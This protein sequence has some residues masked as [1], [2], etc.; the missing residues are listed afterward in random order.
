MDDED[1]DE[2]L[3]ALDFDV[4]TLSE[5]KSKQRENLD[6]SD[7]KDWDDDDF[8]TLTDEEFTALDQDSGFFYEPKS[9]FTNIWQTFFN[10]L[11]LLNSSNGNQMFFF[12]L[13]ALDCVS[14]LL[15]IF[16]Y[17]RCFGKMITFV[18]NIFFQ[19]NFHKLFFLVG[20][21]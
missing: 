14:N 3:A 20:M 7:V 9:C 8:N 13:T 18:G 1:F 17:I 12:L 2:Q 16:H 5:I 19:N 11:I 6:S 10:L 4:A 21:N 15:G